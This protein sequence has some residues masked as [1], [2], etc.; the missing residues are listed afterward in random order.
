MK[1]KFR[2]KG[3]KPSAETTT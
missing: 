3:S 1:E 2:A